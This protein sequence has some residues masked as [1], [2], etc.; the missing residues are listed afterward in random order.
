MS[1]NDLEV[2]LF[3]HTDNN[4]EERLMLEEYRRDKDKFL[5]RILDTSLEYNK[6]NYLILMNHLGLRDYQQYHRNYAM[7]RAYNA[8]IQGNIDKSPEYYCVL[9]YLYIKQGRLEVQGDVYVDINILA[10]L[11]NGNIPIYKVN[12]GKKMSRLFGS[13]IKSITT[14]KY[15]EY[16][17]TPYSITSILWRCS[18]NKLI[19]DRE[20]KEIL[21]SEKLKYAARVLLDYNHRSIVYKLRIIRTCVFGPPSNIIFSGNDAVNSYIRYYFSDDEL[22]YRLKRVPKAFFVGNLSGSVM[23]RYSDLTSIMFSYNLPIVNKKLM[24]RRVM[25]KLIKLIRKDDSYNNKSVIIESLQRTLPYRHKYYATRMTEDHKQHIRDFVSLLRFISTSNTDVVWGKNC[26][27]S[28]LVLLVGTMIR[29][30]SDLLYDFKYIIND[31]LNDNFVSNCTNKDYLHK[32][33]DLCD[34]LSIY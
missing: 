28:K 31:V 6:L 10:D 8:Y 30:N 24:T 33:E 3:S 26:H 2:Y 25:N 20:L 19:R 32:L 17:T 34:T 15:Y 27:Y 1:D 7:I 29:F 5:D 12:N 13:K 14:L 11:R 9:T 4:S 23:C 22:V 16:I 21:N 18:Y